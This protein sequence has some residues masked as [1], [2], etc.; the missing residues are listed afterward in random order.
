[1]YIN[2]HFFNFLYF[3]KIGSPAHVIK[4]KFQKEISYISWCTFLKWKSK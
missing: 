3:H 4:E 2:N 1:M